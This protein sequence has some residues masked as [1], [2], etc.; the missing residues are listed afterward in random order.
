MQR[1]NFSI[2]K[3][4]HWYSLMSKNSKS[5]EDE[6]YHALDKKF[7]WGAQVLVGKGDQVLYHKNYGKTSNLDGHQLV[8]DQTRFDI[9]SLT[10]VVATVSLC[11]LAHENNQLKLEDPVR[12]YLPN[13]IRDQE[14]TIEQLLTH[15]SGLPAWMPLYELINLNEDYVHKREKV[16]KLIAQVP[17]LARPGVGRV[18]SDLGFILLGFILETVFSQN[19]A[20]LFAEQVASVVGLKKTQFNPLKK[21]HDVEKAD[22]ATCYD[23]RFRNKNL[24]G[25]VQDENCFLLGGATGHA[26]L[27][28]TASEL[29]RF[30][31]WV[32]EIAKGNHT[33]ISKK[34]WGR[35]INFKKNYFLGWDFISQEASQAGDYFSLQSIGH[36]GFTG[37]SL[38]MDFKDKKYIILLSNRVD[39]S[40]ENSS[41]KTFRR[42]IHNLLVEQIL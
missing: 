21:G 32:W 38:W 42:K 24:N 3:R 19:F 13:F 33:M 41:I 9:A 40:L 4:V 25:E 17:Y 27:F 6:F 26:G 36:L 28:S 37:T 15:F 20:A 39:F 10:K 30:V 35:F 18:Y 29:N 8:V 31:Q 2:L 14:I 5:V 7:F 12:K 22:F 1:R 23:F 11:M 34:T 16:I